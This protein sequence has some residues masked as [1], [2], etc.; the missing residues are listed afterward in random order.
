MNAR[1]T[2]PL[3]KRSEHREQANFSYDA[4]PMA[5]QA[6]QQGQLKAAVHKQNFEL[7]CLAAKWKGALEQ[8]RVWAH[9]ANT[10][11]RR[12]VRL[13]RGLILAE[14]FRES[15][16][17]GQRN[18]GFLGL[19]PPGWMSGLLRANS[20]S[21]HPAKDTSAPTQFEPLLDIPQDNGYADQIGEFA[22]ITDTDARLGPTL[23]L[24]TAG[25]Y[26]WLPFSSIRSFAISQPS[27]ALDYVWSP[28]Q[29][30]LWNGRSVEGHI[31][32]RYLDSGRAA[33]AFSPA[34]HLVGRESG[35]TALYGAELK[36]WRTNRGEHDLFSMGRCH[37]MKKTEFSFI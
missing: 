15:V 22:W 36:T 5:S 30:E 26:H 29:V 4:L 21:G 2:H 18:P 8:A 28:S 14:A 17:Q 23:E 12:Q 10:T 19:K 24:M 13:Y 25:G 9:L 37:F 1:Y 34:Q 32:A 35:T 3:L 27:T 7:L 6:H 16:F 33:R 20:A 31:P 11:E